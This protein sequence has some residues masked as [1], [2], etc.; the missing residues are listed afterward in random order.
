MADD[1]DALWD[2]T[3]AAPSP[4]DPMSFDDLW[5]VTPAT[6]SGLNAMSGQVGKG[7]ALGLFD[8]IQGAEAGLRNSLLNVFGYG[9]DKGFWQ[10]YDAKVGQLRE[11]D[12]GYEAAHP[13]L[14]TA[15]QVAGGVAPA[16]VTGGAALPTTAKNAPTLMGSLVKN[17]FGVGLTEAPTVVGL[18]KM[19]LTQGAIMGAGNAVEG[20]RLE[21]ALK[22][23]GVG[24]I[25]APAA[26]KTVEG[27]LGYFGNK[28]AE[29]GVIDRMASQRGSI[30]SAPAS[31]GYSPE[32]ILLAKQ[33]KDT[34]V[35]LVVK[36][37][38]E[39]AAVGDDVPL[40]LPEAVGS[41]KVDR[42]AKFI[43]NYEPSL[44][45]SQRA[46]TERTAGS[47]ER[48]SRLFDAISPDEGMAGAG[49]LVKGADDIFEEADAVRANLTDP[50]YKDAYAQ[51]PTIDTPELMDLIKKD[52]VLSSA[53]ESIKK[54]F[55][56]ADLPDNST[57]ILVKA[58][59]RIYEKAE[60]L[61]AKGF[62][63]EANDLMDTHKRLNKALHSSDA[64]K[65][66]DEIYAKESAGIDALN[67]TF[68]KSLRKVSD[69]KVQNIGQIFNLSADGIEN[70]R[71]TF[72]KN[73]KLGEWNAGIRAHL[74]NVVES[75]G[76]GKNFAQKIVGNT[77][78]ERKLRAALGDSYD[79]VAKGLDF[80][81]RFFQG[82]N[83]Y[84]AG[85]P[86]FGLGDE[87]AAFEKGVGILGKIKDGNYLD[88]I[89][90]FFKGDMPDDLAQEMARIYFDPKRGKEAINR[91]IP[92]LERY[93]QVKTGVGAAGKLAGESGAIQGARF[94]GE[95]PQLRVPTSAANRGS[96][97]QSEE[98][99]KALESAARSL[100]LE[101]KVG[102][103]KNSSLKPIADT[104][105]TQAFKQV[106]STPQYANDFSTLAEKVLPD[107]KAPKKFTDRL[108]KAGLDPESLDPLDLAQIKAE[109][110]G[111]HTIEGPKTKYGT[112]KGLMQ[113]LDGTGKEWHAKLGLEGK[114][115]P[116]NAEQN[117]TIGRAYREYLADRYNGDQRLA[118]AAFNW[119]LGN[120]DKALAKTKTGTFEEVFTLMPA[121]TRKYV[122]KIMN[123]V[124]GGMVKA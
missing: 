91:I 104:D 28:A 117:V 75:T 74:Q 70:L 17:V 90:T 21:G 23:G 106:F 98:I 71:N 93:A 67:Q 77:M 54:T 14:S 52:E 81:N 83:K 11:V 119:G 34:P 96:L 5:D 89:A 47:Q 26:G 18:G 85:S 79:D 25:V 32:E 51:N 66:A 8:E 40:F 63:S 88:A 78:Q 20:E 109:S 64:L 113:L 37:A 19:G 72:I 12:A 116:F 22:G 118:L 10:N 122:T 62:G 86:T 92:L 3:P 95:E 101:T 9:N 68:L 13:Y 45:Y 42:N 55:V 111:V 102:Q 114:Y 39:M 58:R 112:A 33:L 60:D 124:N 73:D 110:S 76:E 16:L 84:Y 49:R 29:S 100:E 57:E 69:E 94:D 105:T 97:G 44:D 6:P 2:T 120:L 24:M 56:N 30:S 59:K 123:D 115:D 7:L 31:T 35:D 87:K 61:R 15:L 38:D 27:I 53:I 36:G 80:E 107:M 4:S 103:S 1:F 46:I 82:K 108:V 48:A 43:A 121:E 41:P 65:Q 99:S 50:L